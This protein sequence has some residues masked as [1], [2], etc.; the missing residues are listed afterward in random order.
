MCGWVKCVSSVSG[1]CRVYEAYLSSMSLSAEFLKHMLSVDQVCP[2]RGV[3]VKC[4]SNATSVRQ[5]CQV[6]VECVKCVSSVECVW[7]V[8][9][10]YRG[11][12]VVTIVPRVCRA[13]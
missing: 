6:C 10:V 1:V 2:V 4:V 11:C 8:S 7:S 12:Q 13:C 3:C 5:V 9:N